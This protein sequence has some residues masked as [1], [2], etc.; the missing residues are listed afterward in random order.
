MM[1]DSGLPV[2]TASLSGL[3]YDPVRRVLSAGTGNGPTRH[4][5]EVPPEVYGL[6]SR[7]SAPGVFF[8]QFV[9]SGRYP[10]RVDANADPR[11]GATETGRRSAQAAV[12]KRSCV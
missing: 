4:Y 12:P 9:D 7:G 8:R 1:R 2:P 3:A 6:L 5:L 10:W 11:H